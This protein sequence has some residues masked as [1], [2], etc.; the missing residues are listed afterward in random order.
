MFNKI[1]LIQEKN[2]K[3]VIQLDNRPNIGG[4]YGQAK[5]SAQ[6]L[7]AWFDA[8]PA[9]IRE[10]V[11]EIIRKLSSDKASGDYIALE[12][13]KALHKVVTS[14]TPEE[15]VNVIK[16]YRILSKN[17]LTIKSDVTNGMFTPKYYRL[18]NVPKVGV[19]VPNAGIS[20]VSTYTNGN[21]TITDVESSYR[22]NFDGESKISFYYPENLQ[23]AKSNNIQN[24]KER[25]SNVWNNGL[26]TFTVASDKA[27]Y[28][29]FGCP[30]ALF[31]PSPSFIHSV[32]ILPSLFTE[33][34][35]LE[36]IHNY[37]K[38]FYTTLQQVFS[39]LKI[40]SH[41]TKLLKILLHYIAFYQKKY[42]NS[43]IK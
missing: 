21:V 32:H 3:K 33:P 1:E 29:D 10:K 17:T 19:L 20:D 26:K 8:Y 28:I 2:I 14:M 15:V 31:E 23:V 6:Q 42:Y 7:K 12:G 13:Y 37:Y 5:L 34:W 35:F 36:S 30:S 40:L 43:V 25:E 38:S 4:A 41:I 9:I 22:W 16:L 11:D 39:Y 27:S 18:A 24:W